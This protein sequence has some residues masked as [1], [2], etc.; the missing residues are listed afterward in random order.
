MSIPARD[1]LD[2]FVD[3][4]LAEVRPCR[5]AL[6]RRPNYVR[7]IRSRRPSGRSCPAR[8]SRPCPRPPRPT[9]PSPERRLPR[10]PRPAVSGTVSASIHPGNLRAKRAQPWYPLL[11]QPG[12][13]CL[14]LRPYLLQYRATGTRR[15]GLSFAP[16][17][18]AGGETAGYRGDWVCGD[19]TRRTQKTHPSNRERHG[20]A[21]RTTPPSCRR[22]PGRLEGG[23]RTKA[24]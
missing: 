19:R 18:G 15:Q 3:G 10:R 11:H 23:G 5:R 4:R 20:I 13:A 9:E 22:L 17:L 6:G 21:E 1:H 12:S 8:G 7:R 24:Y 2:R 14:V 16:L